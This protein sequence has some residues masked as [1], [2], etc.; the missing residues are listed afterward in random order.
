MAEEIVTLASTG[1]GAAMELFDHELKRVI[2]NI[3]DPNT[4]N[5]R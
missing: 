2:S 3:G 4:T 1:N 5:D